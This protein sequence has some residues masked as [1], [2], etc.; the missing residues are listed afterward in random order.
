MGFSQQEG[1]KVTSIFVMM[2]TTYIITLYK[3]A[4]PLHQHINS[5]SKKCLSNPWT[6]KHCMHSLSSL[7]LVCSQSPFL[8]AVKGISYTTLIC[9]S[10][11][12]GK[13]AGA[14]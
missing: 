5:S 9:F 12:W 7:L 8:L 14:F 13:G 10:V 2:F 4:S 3:P 6:E 1:M 11:F